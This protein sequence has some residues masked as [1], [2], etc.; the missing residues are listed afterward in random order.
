MLKMDG[1][2][3]KAGG[4]RGWKKGCKW[5]SPEESQ[6]TA[7]AGRKDEEGRAWERARR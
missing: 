1:P 7:E 4:G 6:E 3:R 2:A 5:K